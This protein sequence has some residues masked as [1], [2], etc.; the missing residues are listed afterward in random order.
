MCFF[1]CKEFLRGIDHCAFGLLTIDKATRT[2]KFIT[3]D[4][5]EFITLLENNDCV[6]EKND[7]AGTSRGLIQAEYETDTEFCMLTANYIF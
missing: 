5:I 1:N 4:R 3:I 7:N 2:Q 6:I